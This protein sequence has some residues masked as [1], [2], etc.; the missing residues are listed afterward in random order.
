LEQKL[1]IQK[2]ILEKLDD[3][4]FLLKGKIKPHLDIKEAS[5]Y[6]KIGVPTLYSMVSKRQ[7]SFY[8]PQ[9]KIYFKK[10]ELD[11]WIFKDRYKTDGEIKAEAK[12]RSL[13]I[14]GNAL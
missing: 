14:R 13:H 7:L 12:S 6:L 11:E 8:K 5:E 9:G 10:E 4:I 3:I 2:S 1:N